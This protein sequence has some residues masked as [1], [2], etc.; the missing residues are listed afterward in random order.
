MF[1]LLG[2]VAWV[3][4]GMVIAILPSLALDPARSTLEHPL[5][6][7]VKQAACRGRTSLPAMLRP[8][9]TIGGNGSDVGLQGSVLRF[10]P[11]MQYTM[12]DVERCLMVVV[13]RWER[14]QLLW[15]GRHVL[16][17]IVIQY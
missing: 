5:D 8:T 1:N 9:D 15:L 13:E 17:P 14:L 16:G 2:V 7:Q 3:L 11:T 4:S 12:V 6:R 10:E